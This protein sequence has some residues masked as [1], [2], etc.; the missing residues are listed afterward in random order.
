MTDTFLLEAAVDA[1]QQAGGLLRAAFGTASIVQNKPGDHNLV[2]QFDVQA[3]TLIRS[4][5]LD[6]TPGARVI[7]EEQG[8]QQHVGAFQHITWVVDPLDGTVNFAHGIPFFAVSIAGY[9]DNTIVCGAVMLPMFDELFTAIRGGGSFLNG[10]PISCSQ[11]QFPNS[12]LAT[13]FPYNVAENPMRCRDTFEA[14][15]GGGRPIRRLGSAALDLAYVACGRFDGYWEAHLHSWDFA[16][17]ALLV[18]EAGGKV[19][20][21]NETS[22]LHHL[23]DSSIVAGNESVYAHLLGIVQH[24]AFE[25]LLSNVY[26]MNGAGNRFVVACSEHTIPVEA[27]QWWCG[28]WSIPEAEG[29]LVLRSAS[30]NH[31]V[32]DYYNPDGSFGMMCGNGARCIVAYAQRHGVLERSHSF[33][34]NGTEYTAKVHGNNSVSIWLPAPTETRMYPTGTLAGIT[35]P[36]FYTNVRSNHVVIEEPVTEEIVTKLRHHPAFPSGVNVNIIETRDASIHIR[37]FERGVEQYTQACGTGAVS[38]ALFEFYRTGTQ[39]HRIVPPSQSPLM[40]TIEG[41]QSTIT[42]IELNGTAEY[43]Y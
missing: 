26:K 20:S 24:V 17:G 9:R 16:A 29:L 11:Q 5:L 35:I 37:T 39:H 6:H 18:H 8:Q 12:L 25:Q 13:G 40:V 32:A 14:I 4:V 27:V 34:L 43:D 2:T 3:E 15:V 1:A 30:S 7:G 41:S 38:V 28:R 22:L 21:Y 10:A 19:S 23:A 42:S 31:F 33:L 36:V